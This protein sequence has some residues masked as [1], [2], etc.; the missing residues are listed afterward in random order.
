MYL[1]LPSNTP[2]AGFEI[3][4]MAEFQLQTSSLE[5][6]LK[7]VAFDSKG[8][9]LS[10]HQVI[11]LWGD[12]NG[13]EAFF[14][15]LR[16]LLRPF[17]GVFWEHPPLTLE[18]L[19]L[20]YECVLLHSP[21]L[22]RVAAADTT[23]FQEHFDDHANVVVFDN[24]GKDSRLIV[25]TPDGQS[26]DHYA[27]LAPFVKMAQLA[28]GIA[29]LQ[30]TATELF[31]LLESQPTQARWLSTSGLGVYWLHI[32]LDTRPK[33]YTYQPYITA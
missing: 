29:L 18:R 16:E 28:Q 27:H 33:Y 2:V 7:V 6:G 24:L 31:Q 17:A 21:A 22:A 11:K 25:P 26:L 5:R 8:Q 12:Q 9:S 32:R 4:P 13:A 19:A 10:F 23:S 14:Y 30:Q 3:Q 1:Y 15:Q 20:P